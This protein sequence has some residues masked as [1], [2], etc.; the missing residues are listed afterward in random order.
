[1]YAL[2]LFARPKWPIPSEDCFSWNFYLLDD[3]YG[4]D[5]SIEIHL[6]AMQKLS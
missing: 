4:E 3:D 5:C 1:M 6:L 2:N